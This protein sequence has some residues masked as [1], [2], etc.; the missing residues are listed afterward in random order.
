MEQ[1]KR[2]R[3]QQIKDCMGDL[4]RE[5]E[6]L[7]ACGSQSERQGAITDEIERLQREFKRLTDEEQ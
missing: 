7:D 6:R 5:W 2:Q 1:D 4:R 3:A